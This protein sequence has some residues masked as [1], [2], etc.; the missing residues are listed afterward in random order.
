MFTNASQLILR[1]QQL[2]ENKKV[3]I[4]D[5]END[6]LA[7]E[8]LNVA[9]SVT[10][11][12]LDYHHH[13]ALQPAADHRL[14]CEFGHQLTHDDKFDI[15]IIYF[16]KAKAL[17][18]YLLH[19]AANY[20][21]V[22]GQ[23][24]VVGE[25][26]GGIKS[27]P[28]LLPEFFSHIN[29]IDSARHCLC[30]CAELTQVA[31]KFSL[32][33]W[34]SCYSLATS[35][36]EITICNLVGVF[37]EKRVDQGTELLLNNLPSLSGRIL[38]FGCGAG[39]ISAALLKTNPN[40]NIECVDIN[41]MALAACELTLKAN[42]MRGKVYASDGLDQ[43]S[44]NFDAIISNPPFHDGLES[45]L[46]ITENFIKSSYQKLKTGGMLQ[47]VANRHLP[48]A[49]LLAQYFGT[50]TIL[51]ENNKYKIYQQIK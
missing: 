28:K 45:T 18:P 31:P 49:E 41:A 44:G 5:H 33:D 27:L 25:N 40:M 32:L 8:L 42:G 39:V 11:L 10:A 13:L 1:N 4:L 37:S 17:A 7:K 30:Y 46:A 34:R 12:A 48:Y 2:I 51:A 15:V 47:I 26:K 14:K 20:L 50:A 9:H 23:I 43:T 22:G 3:L 19:L 29:K 35:H 16:P 36:G 21:H 6:L 38:D 24:L